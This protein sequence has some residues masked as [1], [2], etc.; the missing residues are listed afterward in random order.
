M[1]ENILRFLSG[2]G[3][4]SREFSPPPLKKRLRVFHCHYVQTLDAEYLYTLTP[5]SFDRIEAGQS[6]V[7]D[8][9]RVFVADRNSLIVMPTRAISAVGEEMHYLACEE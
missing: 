7:R 6:I 3:V 2:M 8:G 4:I 5:A 1:Y 9:E